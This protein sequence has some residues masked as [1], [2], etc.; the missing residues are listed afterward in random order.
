MKSISKY[1]FKTITD[2]PSNLSH[3]EL[4]LSIA[5]SSKISQLFNISHY[6]LSLNID[7]SSNPSHYNIIVWH[8]LLY[9]VLDPQLFWSWPVLTGWRLTSTRFT[10]YLIEIQGSPLSEADVIVQY[11]CSSR[12]T[13]FL[14]V[15]QEPISGKEIYRMNEIVYKIRQRWAEPRRGKETLKIIEC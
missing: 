12:F 11:H 15:T 10:P 8:I 4:S 6:E 3:Y 14:I 5:A 2:V 7:E 9:K 1:N 13:P